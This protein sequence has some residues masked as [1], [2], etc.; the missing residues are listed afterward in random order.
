MDSDLA[1]GGAVATAFLIESAQH[2]ARQHHL[3]DQSRGLK[4]HLHR[5]GLH[6][7]ELQFNLK[8]TSKELGAAMEEIHRRDAVGRHVVRKAGSTRNFD[9]LRGVQIGGGRLMT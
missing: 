7:E 1:F 3:M 5:S 6:I 8:K 2:R 4:Q 9:Q